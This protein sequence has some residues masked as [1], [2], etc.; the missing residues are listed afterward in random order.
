MSAFATGGIFGVVAS[1]GKM[2]FDAVSE[3][4]RRAEENVV[5]L[6]DYISSMTPKMADSLTTGTA[7]VSKAVS[8]AEADVQKLIAASNGKISGT[9]QNNVARLNVEGLQKVT[10]GMSEA[11]KKAIAAQTAY[12]AKME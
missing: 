8:E 3:S 4:I 1:L 6:Y 5:R 9:V 11:S 2:A 10:D 12:N 7:N